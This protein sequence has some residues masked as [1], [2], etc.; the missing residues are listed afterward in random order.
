MENYKVLTGEK[1]LPALIEGINELL[2][3]SWL[4][5]TAVSVFIFITGAIIQAGGVSGNPLSRAGVL[6]EP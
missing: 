5:A 1:R 6:V 3:R 4:Q 2:V